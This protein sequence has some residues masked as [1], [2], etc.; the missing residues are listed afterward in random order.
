MCKKIKY[1]M[2]KRRD[3]IGE[4]W[5]KVSREIREKVMKTGS[6]KYLN[7]IFG[8]IAIFFTGFP[9]I[10]SI[11]QPYAMEVTGWSR[12]QASMCFYIYFVT[13]VF[14]N[15]LGGR[16]Q[17]KYSPRISV[18]S[19]G[20]IFT[21]S[22]FLSAFAFR[23]SPGF[24]YVTYGILQGFGQGMIYT[25]II[26]TVQKWF[27]KRTGLAS[28]IIVGANAIFGFFMSPVSRK[29]LTLRGIEDT[30]LIMTGAIGF[31]WI[32]GSLFVCNPPDFK[33]MDNGE[34]LPG[35]QYT[36]MEMIRTGKFYFMLCTLLF[37]L[38]PYLLVSPVAQTLL[39]DRGIGL[40]FA[41]G[42]VMTGSVCN[43][44]V[45]LLLP[46]I[47][48]KTGRIICIKTVLVVAAAAMVLLAAAPVSFTGVAI[49]LLYSC[50]GGMMGTF[51]SFC[52]AVFG[53][54]HSGENYGY[55][56]FGLA[57]A[58]LASPFIVNVVTKR[59]MGMETVF[60]IGAGC[61]ITASF[62]LGMLENKLKK[63]SS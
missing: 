3:T 29:L 47:A 10:W 39:T 13:F 48:D 40:S 56:L 51:P 19:G 15:I 46:A 55:L 45:R 38:I 43:A 52:S 16:L 4:D 60:W 25:T 61:A 5:F 9:H 27:P 33:K 59:G 63:G 49:V 31:S 54:K 11:Y 44:A 30:F 50:Y 53:I 22:I 36:S 35:K 34:A 2:K 62:F 12:G 23:P 58:T 20:G 26:S 7:L 14:G 37:G 17:D 41:V 24:M 21:L 18:I 32:F 57:A 6:S 1:D 28:G 8:A 42:V